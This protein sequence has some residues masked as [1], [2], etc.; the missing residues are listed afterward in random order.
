M[1]GGPVRVADDG[2]GT[3]PG[4]VDAHVEDE[5]SL[6]ETLRH[7]IL[8]TDVGSAAGSCGSSSRS[9]GRPDLTG[10]GEMGF[11]LSIFR[12]HAGLRGGPRG[13]RGAT[14]AGDRFLAAATTE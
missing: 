9:R 6:A 4:L 13:A 8:A 10:A 14:A 7:L 12:V 5:W 2:R 3:P 1:G 11:D